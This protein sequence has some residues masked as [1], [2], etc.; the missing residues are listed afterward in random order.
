MVEAEDGSVVG[1]CPACAMRFGTDFEQPPAVDLNAI[2]PEPVFGERNVQADDYVPAD[3]AQDD[4]SNLSPEAAAGLIARMAQAREQEAADLR[5]LTELLNRQLA[6]Q[7]E[8][9]DQL[10]Q[11]D[12]RIHSLEGET[13]RLRERLRAMETALTPAV[14]ATLA[15]APAASAPSASAADEALPDALAPSIAASSGT[16]DTA[17][18]PFAEAEPSLEAETREAFAPGRTAADAV[19]DTSAEMEPPAVTVPQAATA[20]LT[21]TDARRLW[22]QAGLGAEE[23]RLVQR[24]FAESIYTE[25]MRAV[26][27]SLGRPLVNLVPVTGDTPRVMVTIAWEIVWYQFMVDLS[28]DLP[29]DRRVQAFAEGMELTELS[30]QFQ[31]DNASLDQG[32]RVD[33][34]ELEL[35]LLANPPELIT[36]IPPD[37]AAAL[38]DATEEIWNKRGQP[39]FRWDD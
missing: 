13:Q 8:L 11:R 31:D 37:R 38:D 6:D 28:E 36:E 29:E 21:Q 1:V 30:P 14:D 33:A 2:E 3:D 25:K 20:G 24:Y 12:S 15:D 9:Q 22:D 5:A 10:S 23:L 34:S 16:E 35:T 7:L 26:R 32:G 17:S 18:V 19:L 27:R 4:P 39:E